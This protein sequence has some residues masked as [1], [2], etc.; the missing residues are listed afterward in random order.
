MKIRQEHEKLMGEKLTRY[1]REVTDYK[2]WHSGIKILFVIYGGILVT[3]WLFGKW[4]ESIGVLPIFT[5][6]YLI[7]CRNK[8]Q[9]PI[10]YQPMLMGVDMYMSILKQVYEGS[11]WREEVHVS[12]SCEAFG[13]NMLEEIQKFLD[14]PIITKYDYDHTGQLLIL[15]TERKNRTMM[16]HTF[17]RNMGKFVKEITPTGKNPITIIQMADGREY[18]APSNE[19]VKLNNP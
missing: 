17:T 9:R 16:V 2:N 1:Q 4:F 8:P 13:T 5:F 19:F 11:S 7:A 10:F 15:H 14:N 12:V 6:A 3:F 18:F